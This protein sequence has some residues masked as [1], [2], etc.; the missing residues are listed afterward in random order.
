[1]RLGQLSRKL[2]VK[3]EKIV[4]FLAKEKGLE[5]GS[6]P[7]TKVDDVLVDELSAHFAPVIEVEEPVIEV[8][9]KAIE[10]EVIVEEEEIAEPLPVV[11]HIQT[12]KTEIIEPKIIGKIDLPNKKDIQVEI[13][14][15]VY[16]QEFLDQKKKDDLKASREEKI[17]EKEAKQK[18]EQ[19][20]RA[21]AME[22]RKIEAER[23]AMLAQEKHNT[24]SAE[25]E[26]KKAK[27]LKEQELREQKLEQKRKKEQKAHYLN[28]VSKNQVKSKKKKA[29][30]KAKEVETVEV[31]STSQQE[32]VEQQQPIEASAFKRFI[33]WL[34][35]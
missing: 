2:E 24:L 34:N 13:D 32:P 3:P 27:L 35:T 22:Q 12:P 28:Q 33:K 4:S 1:M 14:G 18:E 15:V 11:E 7:N 30:T 31:K 29:P 16:D 5:I 10:P 9:T 23:E 19:E 6:H 8:E 26:K 20:K 17:K 21:L 25:E